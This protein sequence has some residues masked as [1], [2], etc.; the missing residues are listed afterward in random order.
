MRAESTQSRGAALHG[1]AKLARMSTLHPI[2][3]RVALA[4]LAALCLHSLPAAAAPQWKWRDANGSIQYSD[5][6]PPAGTPE[7]SI[8]ARPVAPTSRPVVKAVEAPPAQAATP[9]SPA[10]AAAAK[11][12]AELEAR[13]RK[14][15]E[16]KKA[17]MKAEEERQAKVRAEN[18]QRATAYMKSLQ[19]G[20]RIARTNAAGER[21]VLDDAG[22][23]DE[24]RRTQEV[25][26][27]NCR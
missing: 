18:C 3:S 23:A 19:D 10:S 14:A 27:S 24:M 9:V 7:Q 12:D 16:E 5:R 8:L 22:R 21:E 20:I 25:M 15:E 13:R 6:P 1:A 26:S 11:A 4:V 17:Q 2:S